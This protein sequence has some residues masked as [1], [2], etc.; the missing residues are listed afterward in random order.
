MKPGTLPAAA[1]AAIAL[2]GC[3]L[4]NPAAPATTTTA[5]P[6]A[7]AR[8]ATT[9]PTPTPSAAQINRQ[10]HP[11]P[12]LEHAQRAAAASRPMLPALPITANGVTIDV[13]GLAADGRTTVLTL[14][15]RLGR[16]HALAVYRH[17]LRRY[18]DTGRAYQ[19]VV[20]R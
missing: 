14:T 1:A 2:A 3:G 17:E 12:T 11:S 4:H 8:T 5:P 13:G 16:A 15:T 6:A 10:D 9:P 7:A 19:P 18:G 20:Q